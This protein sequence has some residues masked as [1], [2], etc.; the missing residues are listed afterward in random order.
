MRS[1]PI[2]AD[3][4]SELFRAHGE[5]RRL[6]ILKDYARAPAR[7]RRGADA[8]VGYVEPAGACV[9]GRGVRQDRLVHA[10]A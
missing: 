9:I 6:R 4:V 2:W 3:P 7:G 1:A 8:G 10:T 5:L